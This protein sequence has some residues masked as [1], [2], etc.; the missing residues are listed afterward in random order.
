MYRGVIIYAPE[1]QP[2]EQL[3]RRLAD[4]FDGERFKVTTCSADQAAIPDLTAAD[5]FLLASLP[6][7]EQ[8]IHPDFAEI[9]RA[10]HGI[11]LA[12]RVGGAVSLESEPTVKAFRRALQDC[13]LDLPDR[14]F[15]SLS[16][17]QIEST[18]LNSWIGELTSQLGDPAR[19]R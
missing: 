9:L 13:E 8:P 4:C 11:T 17:A 1:G 6:A 19:G 5:I 2:L 15:R 12:G 14:N 16:R 7:G 10:L 18:E 3:V